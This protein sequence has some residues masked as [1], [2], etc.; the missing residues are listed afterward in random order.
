VTI[1]R[2]QRSM[3]LPIGTDTLT[4][5]R[6]RQEGPRTHHARPSPPS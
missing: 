2:G 1:D 4:S 5:P 6:N 3:S